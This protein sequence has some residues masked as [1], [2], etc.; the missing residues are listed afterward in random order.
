MM[1]S[2]IESIKTVFNRVSI[3]GN[4]GRDFSIGDDLRK[5]P[6]V[7]KYLQAVTD[8]FSPKESLRGRDNL[9]SWRRTQPRPIGS[10][11]WRLHR[12]HDVCQNCLRATQK[13]KRYFHIYWLSDPFK[14]LRFSNAYRYVLP[15]AKAMFETSGRTSKGW[16]IP[17][18]WDRIH[19]DYSS[20]TKRDF[21]RTRP[22]HHLELDW[23]T[24][25]LEFSRDVIVENVN[26]SSFHGNGTR[27]SFQSK[28]LWDVIV[29]T[30]H[31]ALNA[32]VPRNSKTAVMG[33][34]IFLYFR[35]TKTASG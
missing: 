32:V 34:K 7:R 13:G 14:N 15:C 30:R 28:Y 26:F 20:K 21:V 22:L 24:A 12:R 1:R 35:T 27:R 17:M 23:V 10:D 33:R 9:R 6:E 8:M 18:R 29:P 5:Y 4:T 11:H 31:V 19:L 16:V 3:C 25:Q 2:T